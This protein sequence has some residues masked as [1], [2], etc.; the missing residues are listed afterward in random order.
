MQS[1]FAGFQLNDTRQVKDATLWG[2]G[3]VVQT[4]SE[5]SNSADLPQLYVI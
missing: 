4:H 3:K 5:S 2:H 1:L